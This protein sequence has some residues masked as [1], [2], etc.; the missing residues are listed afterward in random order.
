M[1]S[2]KTQDIAKL[3]NAAEQIRQPTAHRYREIVG[4]KGAVAQTRKWT[5]AHLSR[6]WKGLVFSMLVHERQEC[7]QQ[8]EGRLLFTIVYVII[9]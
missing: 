4:I 9:F 2:V 3:H 6:Y 5:E 1:H 7:V 8:F